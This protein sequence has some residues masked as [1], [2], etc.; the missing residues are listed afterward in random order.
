MK[1]LVSGTTTRPPPS[2]IHC[3]FHSSR[4]KTLKISKLRISRSHTTTM[5]STIGRAA[6][7]RVVAAGPQSTNRA[8]HSIWQL[9]RAALLKGG[10]DGRLLQS[11]VLFT[12]TRSYATTTKATPKPKSKSSTTTKAK[13]TAKPRAKKASTK[14]T[15]KVKAKK[16]VKKRV[17]KP[18]KKPTKKILSVEQKERAVI[19]TLREQ[20]LRIPKGKPSSPWIVYLVEQL[21][22]V[23]GTPGNITA[24]SPSI[25]Q[26]YKAVTPAELEVKI[27]SRPCTRTN[28][29]SR[30]T[31]LPIKTRLRMK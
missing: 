16:P 19:K 26:D 27:P 4:I 6:V 24:K 28:Y 21:D 22:K 2:A 10:D 17:A 29:I 30:S 25:R 31:T 1:G 11:N 5:L 13:A 7:K 15:V 18:K 3:H 20:A 9:Q 12:Y 8:Y 14:K 23:K